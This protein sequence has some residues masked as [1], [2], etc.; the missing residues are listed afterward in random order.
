[1][2]MLKRVKLSR[3][4]GRVVRYHTQYLTRPETVAEHVFGVL[5]ILVIMTEGQLSA[6]LLKAALAH[7][8]GEYISGDVPSPVKRRVP[9]MR[10]A[11]NLIEN[12]AAGAIYYDAAGGPPT[13]WEHT[14]LK[15]ADNLDGL[16]KCAE[17]RAMGNYTISESYGDG[18]SV[19]GN[20][21]AYLEDMLPKLGGGTAA[22]LVQ[23]AITE[24]HWGE[25]K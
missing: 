22:D 6:T 25:K 3:R 7:D 8:S 13:E 20:Y 10:E 17:E 4:A 16:L 19:G 21:C 2:T 23:A 1:M 12:G 15:V 24:W 5:N 18:T 11:V 9:G 14:L